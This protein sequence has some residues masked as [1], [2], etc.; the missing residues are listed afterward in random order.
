MSTA[1]IDFE[2]SLEEQCEAIWEATLAEAE[3]E[4]RL[5]DLP[6]VTQLWDGD[7]HLQYVVEMEYSASFDLIDGDTG[8]GQIVHPYD[9]PAGR[10]LVDT[11][12]RMQRGEKRNVVITVDYTGARWGG[13]L[14]DVTLE[15]DDATGDQIVTATF[16]SDYEQLKWYH[17]WSNPVLPAAVQIPRMFILPGPTPWVLSTSLFLQIL[18]EQASLWAIPD[19]PTKLS[20]WGNLNQSNWSVVVKP[21]SF[22]DSMNSGALWGIATS[23]WRNWHEMAKAMMKDAE[24]TPVVRRYLNGDPPPWPGANIRH[25]A[26]VISFEDKSGTYTGTSNGGTAWDGL[27]RTF[28]SFAADFIDTT[29]S[30]LTDTEIPPEYF[31][32]G[33]KRTS[34]RLP[35]A[36]WFDGEITGLQG[37]R[38]KQRP[39][40][41]VQILTGGHSMPGVNEVISAGIQA[42]GD[43][44]GN[45]AQIGSIGGSIDTVLKPFY[46]DTILAWIS[47][48]SLARA[49]NSGWVRYFEFFQDGSGK[50]YTIASLMALRAGF[51]ATRA[52]STHE[53]NVG[54][55]APFLIGDQGL[56]HIFLGDR[57]GATVEN[58]PTG[59]IYIQRMGKLS[60]AWD[61][62]SPVQWV[63]TFGDDRLLQDPVQA[64]W[65]RIE[66]YRDAFQQLGV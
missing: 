43:V 29:T 36:I 13:I 24:I 51:W 7:M 54:D 37:Y 30:L 56:G 12:G 28:E 63:P 20:N 66:A 3:Q 61:R 62:T 4:Q 59:R 11:W 1:T 8:P 45:L 49:Q 9:H 27:L 5:R 47:I 42:L 48:K 2:L 50:A 31:V 16:A 53:I 58:D 44:L 35:Y 55:G 23:R 40:Q 52:F 60:L 32:P 14:S 64:A 17:V 25:G 15:K 38:L 18:R 33:D 34:K 22:I 26:L 65:D 21:L 10:W 46:E 39:T 19:D 57:G 6:P 41:A